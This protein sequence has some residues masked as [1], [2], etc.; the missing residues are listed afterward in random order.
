MQ[1]VQE[2]QQEKIITVSGEGM[3]HSPDFPHTYPRNTML[4]WRLVA[5]SNMKIQ[6]TF[7]ERFGLEDPED[8]IC[9]DPETQRSIYPLCIMLSASL[10][11]YHN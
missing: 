4:V 1:R 6:L 7:D 11:I 8:G 9:K 10:S 2:S 3:V 5:S